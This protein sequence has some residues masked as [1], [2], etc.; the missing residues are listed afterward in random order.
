LASGTR[1]EVV[2]IM[3]IQPLRSLVKHIAT[4][5]L[6]PIQ[7]Q[8]A[9]VVVQSLATQQANTFAGVTLTSLQHRQRNCDDAVLLHETM[10]VYRL[11]IRL[12]I[13]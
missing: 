6:P 4:S 3:S 11:P 1:L 13:L 2:G 9:I 7:V 5:R 8:F 12:Q 10:N